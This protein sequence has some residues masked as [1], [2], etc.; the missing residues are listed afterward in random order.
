MPGSRK[1]TRGANSPNFHIDQKW[2][3]DGSSVEAAVVEWVRAHDIPWIAA[4]REA[5]GSKLVHVRRPLVA[6]DCEGIGAPCEAMRI[7][8]FTHVIG[9]YHHFMSCEIDVFART[10]FLRH[11][12]W[13]DLLHQNMLDRTWP[14]G[15]C[16]DLFSNGLTVLPV[17]CDI[18]V[19]GF[20]CQP[21]SL[22]HS[23]SAVFDEA[24]VILFATFI[25]P[26]HYGIVVHG[27]LD[28]NFYIVPCECQ[29]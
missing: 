13:P 23:G 14:E 11:H 17:G 7:M 2:R 1:R 27:S 28:P 12:R 8:E 21:F 22:R 10:W 20:P 24:K 18:Y 5:L 9:S 16:M 3:D 15:S 26:L 29:V 25:H 6:T 19:C 4:V